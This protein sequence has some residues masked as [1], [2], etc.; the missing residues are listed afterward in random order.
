M[1]ENFFDTA[2]EIDVVRADGQRYQA[3]GEVLR[4]LPDLLCNGC[5]SLAASF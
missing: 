4:D 3:G 5:L 2:T 1:D